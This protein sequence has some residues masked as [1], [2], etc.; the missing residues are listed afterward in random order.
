MQDNLL[1]DTLSSAKT[2]A[3]VGVSSVKKEISSNIKRRPSIIVMK[4][5]QDFGYKV[6]PVNPF[7]EGQEVNGEKIVANLEDIKTPVDIV[8]VFRPSEETPSIAEQAVKI[9]AKVLWLQYGIQN[10][11]AEDITKAAKM[12]YIANKCI[13]QEYQRLFLKVNPVFPALKN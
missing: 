8:D 3:M 1:K 10:K 11:A 9:N 12:I 6:I 13:K 2:I 4:Y 5:M 7:S